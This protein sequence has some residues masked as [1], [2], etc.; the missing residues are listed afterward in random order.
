MN[1][2]FL[3][4]IWR[5]PLVLWL[6]TPTALVPSYRVM[7]RYPGDFTMENMCQQRRNASRVCTM[8]SRQIPLVQKHLES[9][10]IS[11]ILQ[12]T[13]GTQISEWEQKFVLATSCFS[14]KKANLPGSHECVN[15]VLGLQ[16]QD[17]G[18][19]PSYHTL[20]HN[21]NRNRVQVYYM[22][23]TAKYGTLCGLESGGND[24]NTTSPHQA[25][26]VF[27]CSPGLNENQWMTVELPLS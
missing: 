5:V 10:V 2:A 25:L 7:T 6:I 21:A 14:L 11:L 19:R 8:S 27:V 15:I 17:A 16:L 12:E 13:I 24:S 4:C 9:I 22:I 18:I 3:S 23:L 1:G 26:A 20:P